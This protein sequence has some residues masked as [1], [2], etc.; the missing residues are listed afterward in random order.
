MLI[1]RGHREKVTNISR[2]TWLISEELEFGPIQ[3]GSRVYMLN[4]N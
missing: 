2:A 3:P 4:T 1:F